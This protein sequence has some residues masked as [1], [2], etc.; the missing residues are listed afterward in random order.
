ML[1]VFALIVGRAIAESGVNL[2]WR[3]AARTLK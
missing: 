1:A 2:R 3:F